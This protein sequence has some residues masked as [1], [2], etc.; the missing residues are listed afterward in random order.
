LRCA[1]DLS[2]EERILVGVALLRRGNKIGV[3]FLE[4]QLQHSRIC[5][6]AYIAPELARLG[7]PRALQEMSKLARRTPPRRPRL[8]RTTPPADRAV[9]AVGRNPYAASSP[10]PSR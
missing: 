1:A 7:N 5:Y 8:G 2:V 9:G 6:R 3:P 4:E 10:T